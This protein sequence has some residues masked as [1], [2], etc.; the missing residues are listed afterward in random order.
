MQIYGHATVFIWM[1]GKINLFR[2]FFAR[3]R[4]SKGYFVFLYV[5]SEK[6]VVDNIR[7]FGA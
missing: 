1:H 3:W 2:L 7:P 5:D 6:I 4:P